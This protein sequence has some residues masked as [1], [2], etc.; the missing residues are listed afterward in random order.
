MWRCLCSSFDACISCVSFHLFAHAH[1]GTTSTSTIVYCISC[2]MFTSFHCV[3]AWSVCVFG[4]CVYVYVPLISFFCLFV[5]EPFIEE[6]FHS[7]MK[8]HTDTH[9]HK[10][11]PN[12][13]SL[14]LKTKISRL[15]IPFNRSLIATFDFAK[16]KQSTYFRKKFDNES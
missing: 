1:A 7:K 6:I 15:K 16:K 4:E 5:F 10:T 14:T 11:L 3:S 13:L 8:Q 12:L 2:I 9:A